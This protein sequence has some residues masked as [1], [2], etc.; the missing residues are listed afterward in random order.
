M[1]KFLQSWTPAAGEEVRTEDRQMQPAAGG[2]PGAY[3]GPVWTATGPS[4]QRVA[5][6]AASMSPVRER[7][8]GEMEERARGP[9]PT[10]CAPGANTCS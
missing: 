10:R 6:P 1:G 9:A 2:D 5:A 4:A 8:L 7:K 3:S